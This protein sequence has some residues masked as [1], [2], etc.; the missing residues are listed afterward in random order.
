[1][2][3]TQEFFELCATSFQHNKRLIF[4]SPKFSLH[5]VF[6]FIY[7]RVYIRFLGNRPQERAPCGEI[8]FRAKYISTTVMLGGFSNINFK[9]QLSTLISIMF[10]KL[11]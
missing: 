4:I 7:R 9:N 2:P 6:R 3:P 5:L 8:N 11:L 10:Q 1:M